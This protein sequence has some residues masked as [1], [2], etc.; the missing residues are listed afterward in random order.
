MSDHCGL[1]Y[2]V[3]QLDLNAI[4]ARL[5]VMITEFYFNISYVKGKENRVVY[6]LS[7]RVQV[8]HITTMSSYG[9]NL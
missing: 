4:S 8:N 1:R 3:D 6:A 5:M 7:R 9:T 2:L